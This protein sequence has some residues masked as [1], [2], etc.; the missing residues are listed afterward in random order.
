MVKSHTGDDSLRV[1]CT[2]YVAHLDK[3]ELIKMDNV[4]LNLASVCKTGPV[5]MERGRLR[6]HCY[7]RMARRRAML[8]GPSCILLIQAR[9]LP[10]P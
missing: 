6:S 7:P 9:L 2:A 8:M 10:A 3:L 1:K 5:P 4:L